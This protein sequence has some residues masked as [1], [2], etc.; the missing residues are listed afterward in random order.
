MPDPTPT[1]ALT[2]KIRAVLEEALEA[3]LPSGKPDFPSRLR[4]VELILRPNAG[5]RSEAEALPTTAVIQVDLPDDIAAAMRAQHRPTPRP[6]GQRQDTSAEVP[7]LR[8]EDAL[9]PPPSRARS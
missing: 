2:H 6:A 3:D 1:S 4:A 7:P 5:V 8:P 9:P